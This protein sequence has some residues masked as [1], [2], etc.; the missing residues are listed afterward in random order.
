MKPKLYAEGT[1]VTPEKTKADLE[2]LLINHGA[3]EF[4]S[5]W[6]T[7]PDTGL[8]AALIQFRL[9]GRMLRYTVTRPEPERFAFD[10]N[11]RRRKA[12]QIE[13]RVEAEYWRRWRALFLIIKAK[14]EVVASGDTTFDREFMADI[15]L[16]DGGTVADHMIPQIDQAYLSGTMPALLPP[17]RK[18]RRRRVVSD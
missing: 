9:T 12:D 4:M 1:A 10:H 3:T 2:R 11:K 5:A 8:R 15:M 17:P 14:L 7:N 13:Q 6:G 16:P 18:P